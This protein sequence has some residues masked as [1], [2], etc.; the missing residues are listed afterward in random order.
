MQPDSFGRGAMAAMPL[1]AAALALAL[2]NACA[3]SSELIGGDDN[4]ESESGT[5]KTGGAEAAQRLPSWLHPASRPRVCSHRDSCTYECE[6]IEVP[7]RIRLQQTR[8]VEP[9]GRA[10][11]RS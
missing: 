6:N 1:C 5:G 9:G 8:A 11:A 7:R 2:G 4:G 10:A 3:G